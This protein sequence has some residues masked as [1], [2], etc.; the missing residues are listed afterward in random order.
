[1]RKKVYAFNIYFQL[2]R[3]KYKQRV[4]ML[5]DTKHQNV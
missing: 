2:Q 5:C 1:M 3:F 4:K